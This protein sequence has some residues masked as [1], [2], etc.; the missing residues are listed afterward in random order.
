MRLFEKYTAVFAVLLIFFVVGCGGD[1][2]DSEV[3]GAAIGSGGWDLLTP[4]GKNQKILERAIVDLD[5]DVR[6]SC[7]NWIHR[8][9]TDAS[10]GHVVLPKNNENGDGWND[11]PTGRLSGSGAAF[12]TAA[13]IRTATPGAI[14]QIQW[15]D[16]FGSSLPGYGRHTAIV[17]SVFGS[18]IVFIESNF[19]DTPRVEDG[20]TYVKIRVQSVEEF[21]N[22]VESFTIYYIG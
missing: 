13:Y 15:K 6:L 8:V 10:N 16:G 18:Y 21:Q 17:L 19:D 1:S 7:K 14:V 12:D 9:V 2:E 5:A 20:P 4:H 11:D 22:S 3:G